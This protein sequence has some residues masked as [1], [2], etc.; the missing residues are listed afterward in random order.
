MNRGQVHQSERPKPESLSIAAHGAWAVSTPVRNRGP[1]AAAGLGRPVTRAR[2]NDG[3]SSP[4][5]LRVSASASGDLLDLVDLDAGYAHCHETCTR[6]GCRPRRSDTSRAGGWGLAAP[7]CGRDAPIGAVAPGGGVQALNVGRVN[8]TPALCPINTAPAGGCR[9]Q[10]LNPSPSSLHNTP[11]DGYD[12][13][14]CML[15]D[16]L[17]NVDATPRLQASTPSLPVARHRVPKH[18]AHGFHVRRQSIHAHQQRPRQSAGPD[19]LDQGADTCPNCGAGA[20]QIAIPLRRD[21]A[22]AVGA[23]V[24]PPSQSRRPPVGRRVETCKATLAPALRACASAGVATLRD[25][26]SP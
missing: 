15:L 24:T 17:R 14:F 20:G 1:A 13:S 23:G 26:F 7:G 25:T 12:M 19:F 10:A 11:C 2:S 21:P 18:L 16:D 4:L 5:P 6:S 8:P 9:C 3:R 22:P